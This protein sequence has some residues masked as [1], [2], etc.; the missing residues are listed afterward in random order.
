MRAHM[1]TPSMCVPNMRT[2]AH[3][4]VRAHTQTHASM[5]ARAHTHTHARMQVRTHT[6]THTHTHT[7][8]L[9]KLGLCAGLSMGDVGIFWPLDALIDGRQSWE[10]VT[11]W[12]WLA[13]LS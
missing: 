13:E 6:H 8:S 1:H 11:K 10:I 12:A 5:H 9:R 4:H 7:Q 2:Y 3:V